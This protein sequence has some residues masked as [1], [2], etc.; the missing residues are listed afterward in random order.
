MDKKLPY[1]V[2]IPF[3]F[4]LSTQRKDINSLRIEKDIAFQLAFHIF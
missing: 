2:A 1:V 4:K 3:L